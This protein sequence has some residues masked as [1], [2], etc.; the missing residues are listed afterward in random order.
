[1]G[2]FAPSPTDP[3]FLTL[4]LALFSSKPASCD[5]ELNLN[6]PNVPCPVVLRYPMAALLAQQQISHSFGL[7]HQAFSCFS[8]LI[9]GSCHAS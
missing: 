7:S 1:M 3:E 4:A 2:S 5:T 8:D 6:D 9:I